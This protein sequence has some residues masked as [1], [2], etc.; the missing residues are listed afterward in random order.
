MFLFTIGLFGE[1][2]ASDAFPYIV[3]GGQSLF[4]TGIKIYNNPFGKLSIGAGT[5]WVG[6]RQDWSPDISFPD[7]IIGTNSQYFQLLFSTLDKNDIFFD[8]KRDINSNIEEVLQPAVKSY[9]GFTM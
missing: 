9:G 6:Y 7:P 5:G 3:T 4:S 8:V 2:V 1:G